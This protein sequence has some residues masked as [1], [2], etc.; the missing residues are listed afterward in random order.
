MERNLLVII[1]DYFMSNQDWYTTSDHMQQR[2]QNRNMDNGRNR[3][4]DIEEAA[5]EN[6]RAAKNEKEIIT[7]CNN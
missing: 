2:S 3:F 6:R 1:K 4:I 5:F 7:S